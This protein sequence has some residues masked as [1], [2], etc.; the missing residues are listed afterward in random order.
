[1]MKPIRGALSK[2][3]QEETAHT[4]YSSHWQRSY[5]HENELPDPKLRDPA[6]TFALPT[7]LRPVAD[8][9]HITDNSIFTPRHAHKA[10]RDRDHA[11]PT[12]SA[13]C[14][15]KHY[16]TCRNLRKWKRAAAPIGNFCIVVDSPSC[17][18]ESFR[19]RRYEAC[20]RKPILQR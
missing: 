4:S 13:M 10:T 15:L 20:N 6:E 8:C 7:S 11:L 3:L 18:T 2:R 1:M 9:A 12:R 16:H 17:Q 5:A 19:Y 14:R